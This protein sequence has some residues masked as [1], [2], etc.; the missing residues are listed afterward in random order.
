MVPMP[1][2]HPLSGQLW[3][4]WVGAIERPGGGFSQ[5][6]CGHHSA[7]HGSGLTLGRGP[8]GTDKA[9]CAQ[10]VKELLCHGA[11]PNLLLT[12][13]LGSALCVACDLIY[14]TQRSM[15]SKLALVRG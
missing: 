1:Q 5:P 9:F 10:I 4:L 12:R 3:C 13:G 11:D 7:Q 2:Q 14:E 15:D 6:K 8:V